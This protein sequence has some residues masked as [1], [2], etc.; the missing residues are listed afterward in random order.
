M[1]TWTIRI[2]IIRITI[3][4]QYYS[5]CAARLEVTLVLLPHVICDLIS[6]RVGS[7]RL[8]WRWWTSQFT[9]VLRRTHLEVKWLIIIVI[10][11][12]SIHMN[13]LRVILLDE[14]VKR[15]KCRRN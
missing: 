11:V 2:T 10:V 3:N 5:S 8:T 14:V 6:P 9:H 12:V 7:G 1:D 15:C 4:Y 13:L